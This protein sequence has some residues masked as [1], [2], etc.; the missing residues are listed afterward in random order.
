MRHARPAAVVVMTAGHALALLAVARGQQIHRNGF[1]VREPVWL[2]GT[3]DTP[4][5]ELAHEITD[6]T[7]HTGQYSEHLQ[8]NSEQGNAIYYY[9]PTSRAPINEDLSISLWVKANRG[10]IQLLARLVLPRERNPNNLQEPLTTLLRGDPYHPVSRWQ[11]LE[12]LRPAKQ[13]AQQ[14]QIMR[15]QLKRDVDFTDAYIDRLLVNVYAG[16]GL[17]DVWID[18]LEIGPVLEPTA[19]GTPATDGNGAREMATQSAPSAKLLPP[20]DTPRK[21]HHSALVEMDR[22]QLLVNRKPFFFRGI[23]HSGTPLQTLRDA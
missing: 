16:P 22:G 5:R 15:T 19:A 14:Q 21:P 23:R 20:G 1:E 12:L 2:K 13:A 4:Y 6:A 7:A 18:D 9:Y 8:I 11:R 10:G 17:T 3:A